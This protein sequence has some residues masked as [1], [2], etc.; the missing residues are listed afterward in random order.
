MSVDIDAAG[1]HHLPIGLDGLHPSRDNQIISNLPGKTV[2]QLAVEK[3]DFK[4][5]HSIVT[6]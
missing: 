3:S 5:R 1:D 2:K 6:F 4:D